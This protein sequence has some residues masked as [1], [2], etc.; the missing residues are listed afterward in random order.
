MGEAR[1]TEPKTVQVTLNDG[2]VAAAARRSRV[3]VR[4]LAGEHSGRA[5]TGRGEAD[6]ARRSARLGALARASGC[7]RRRLRRSGIRAGD[8]PLRQPGHDH[9]TRHATARSRR[10]RCVGALL[11][12]MQDEGIEVML[13]AE[14]L[15]RRGAIGRERS[16][17]GAVGSQ[18]RTSS[19]PPTFWWRLAER[20][21]RI[22]W[23]WLGRASNSI[24]AATSAS[25]KSFRPAP[26]MYGR[27]A[28]VP[29]VRSSRTRAT[30]TFAWCSTISPA[31]IA[32]RAVG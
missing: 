3:S 6:D 32:R 16:T 20:R 14:V 29:A 9:A 5:R 1:F 17:Q 4:R 11:E 18:R 21:T 12:L 24:R 7:S 10:C 2:G 19:K 31:A 28:T 15:E 25:T 27:W 26:R 13:Q 22:G 8:A 23:T 30:M